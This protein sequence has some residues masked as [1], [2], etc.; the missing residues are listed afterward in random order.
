MILFVF[1]E[2]L[3]NVHEQHTHTAVSLY[4]LFCKLYIA[5][6]HS[7]HSVGGQ[8]PFWHRLNRRSRS[9]RVSSRYIPLFWYLLSFIT[10]FPSETV[11]LLFWTLF[12]TYLRRYQDLQYPTSV[13]VSLNVPWCCFSK[14]GDTVFLESKSLL[15][16]PMP[17]APVW[18]YYPREF[19]E[20]RM[21]HIVFHDSGLTTQGSR[22]HTFSLFTDFSYDLVL[23]YGIQSIYTVSNLWNKM[24]HK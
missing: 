17:S 20:T 7:I 10:I 18:W 14:Y 2:R 9:F 19:L 22:L 12:C 15:I 24:S 3:G 16:L 11:G 5:Q 13:E 6:L 8:A 1:H 23:P 4:S 21:R